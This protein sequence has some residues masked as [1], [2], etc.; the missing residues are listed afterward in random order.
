MAKQPVDPRRQRVT[1]H[2]GLLLSLV[3]RRQPVTAYQLFKMHEQSPVISINS[4][5]GQLYPAIRRL[6]E[7]RLLEAHRVAGDARGAEELCLTDDGR[8]ALGSWVS[9]IDDSHIVL[10]DPL[11]TRVPLL[12]VLSREEQFEWIANAKALVRAR[13]AM[14]EDYDRSPE[15]AYQQFA[16]QGA[17]D[18]LLAKMEWL[19]EL[20]FHIASSK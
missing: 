7:R 13:V 17:M 11:R 12:N 15:D 1:E 9:R 6:K 8:S 19:D 3:A 5:K 16:R 18:V 20:L 4:S 10:D 2:E 14:I